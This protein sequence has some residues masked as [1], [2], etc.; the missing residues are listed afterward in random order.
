MKGASRRGRT[1]VMY[2][3]TTGV[4]RRPFLCMLAL[5]CKA[6]RG[7]RPRLHSFVFLLRSLHPTFSSSIFHLKGES[8]QNDVA[9]GEGKG[10]VTRSESECL[11]ATRGISWAS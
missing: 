9:F 2:V 5:R 10:F 6:R 4:R 7:L 8:A 11:R 1:I 3:Q